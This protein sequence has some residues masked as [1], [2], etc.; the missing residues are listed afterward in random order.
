MV[1]Q[2]TTEVGNEKC[3]YIIIKYLKD[4]LTIS[5]LTCL[6]IHAHDIII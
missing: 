1:I 3:S 6:E 5:E 4:S 2:E